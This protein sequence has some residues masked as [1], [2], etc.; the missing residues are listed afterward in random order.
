MTEYHGLGGMMR[1][2]A[3]PPERRGV[4]RVDRL[5]YAGTWYVIGSFPHRLQRGFAPATCSLRGD[6]KIGLLNEC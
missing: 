4:E 1:G 6:G 3:A 5:R 2:A